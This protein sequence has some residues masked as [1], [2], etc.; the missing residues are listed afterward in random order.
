LVVGRVQISP[1]DKSGV[2]TSQSVNGGEKFDA[3]FGE[4]LVKNSGDIYEW[5][6]AHTGEEVNNAIRIPVTNDPEC[7]HKDNHHK[8]F[9]SIGRF[10]LDNVAY[11]GSVYENQGMVFVDVNG[12]RKVVSSFQVLTCASHQRNE[13]EEDEHCDHN[14]L[15]DEKFYFN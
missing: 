7:C 13:V 4:Y 11:V 9:A 14:C 8:K 3:N 6:D 15:D 2:Y 1:A 12:D 10:Y 5:I